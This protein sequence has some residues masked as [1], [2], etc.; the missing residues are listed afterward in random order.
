MFVMTQKG[1]LH[2]FL[3]G[4]SACALLASGTGVFVFSLS[5]IGSPIKADPNP[6]K[7]SSV[8]ALPVDSADKGA[9][10]F[11]VVNPGNKK[12]G[13]ILSCSGCHSFSYF[14]LAEV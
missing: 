13:L 11:P 2:S 6:A 4:L 10:T 14:D 12:R 3:K 8:I 5:K 1:N 9:S 7:R